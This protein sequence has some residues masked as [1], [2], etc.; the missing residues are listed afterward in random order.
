MLV[1]LLVHC[2]DRVPFYRDA[3]AE[4]G[5]IGE[6]NAREVLSRLPVV[7]RSLLQGSPDEFRARGAESTADD[8]T[9]GS[10]GT[11]MRFVVDRQTQIARES[12]LMWADS[13]A[14]WKPG[15]RIAMLW[16]SD[17]D[18]GTALRSARLRLRCWIENRR[19]F[20][21]FQMGDAEMSEYDRALREFRPHH[22]VAY[23]SALHAFASYLKAR[24][25]RSSYPACGL[26]SSAEVLPRDMRRDIEDVFQK[27]VFDRYGNREFGAISAECP[28]HQ[29]SHLN[30]ADMIVEVDSPD[31][32]RI[33]GPIIITY[34]RNFAMPF[35]RYDTGDY[36]LLADEPCPC[37]CT[38]PRLLGIVG[39]RSEMIKTTGGR[40]IHGEFFTHLFYG[41]AVRQFL[42]VQETADEYVL[43][44]VGDRGEMQAA[45]GEWRRRILEAT[46]YGSRLRVVYVDSIPRLPSGKHQFT[47]SKV[48]RK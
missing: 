40:L 46:G 29:G 33:P 45:E 20:N 15:Y 7:A 26:I 42:F 10:T 11:P 38:A 23:A 5:D 17:R 1:R 34:L 25:T 32:R 21:A 16:G 36:G 47:I 27:P 37:G 24:G 6:D 9:G 43:H 4:D 12:S 48:G 14:G 19:W 22:I 31:P 28:A 44:L 41:S 30:C 13:L 35:V 18:V 3:F 8:A 39:R 2:R